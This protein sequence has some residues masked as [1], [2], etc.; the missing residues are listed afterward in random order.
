MSEMWI[1]D[2]S[3]GPTESIAVAHIAKLEEELKA[4]FA[5]LAELGATI[6]RLSDENAPLRDMLKAFVDHE[7]D[8]M[9]LNHLGDPMMVPRIKYAHAAIYGGAEIAHAYG[10]GETFF[11]DQHGPFPNGEGVAIYGTD[12][13][14]CPDA[15]M[16]QPVEAPAPSALV[17]RWRNGKRYEL[18]PEDARRFDEGDQGQSG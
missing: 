7:V 5:D 1:N 4:S 14:E 6:R 10:N 9:R 3:Q 2:G 16:H 12:F 11:V 13:P 18:T 17:T 8:Y 15:S